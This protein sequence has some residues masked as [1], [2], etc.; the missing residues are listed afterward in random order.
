MSA[1]T[2]LAPNNPKRTIRYSV[3]PTAFVAALILAP[4]S[5]TLLTCWTI[6]G[7][8]ALPFGA[9]PYLLLGTP[10]LLW[11]VTRIEPELWSY[12]T[13]GFAVNLVC[14]L[15]SLAAHALSLSSQSEQLVFIFAY[16][17]LFGALYAGAFGVIYANLYPNRRILQ[18]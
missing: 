3:N 7:L 8:F 9:I 6:I 18:I 13:L 14:L 11:A 5:V 4:I 1:A 15:A 2:L 17:L 16:G 12:A 10:V